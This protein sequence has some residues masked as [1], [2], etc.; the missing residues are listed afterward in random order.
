MR[1]LKKFAEVIPRRQSDVAETFNEPADRAKELKH[2][3]GDK[4]DSDCDTN[5]V[6]VINAFHYRSVPSFANPRG[7]SRGQ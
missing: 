7:K 6:A 5:E 1:Y 3:E 2:A 4:A